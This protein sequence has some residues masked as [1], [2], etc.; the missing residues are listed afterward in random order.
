MFIHLT[1][2]LV[3]G[4]LVLISVVTIVSAIVFSSPVD[5]TRLTFGQRMDEETVLEKKR[6][7]GLDL[8]LKD[9]LVLYLADL[10]PIALINKERWIEL[11]Y[12]GVVLFSLDKSVFVF[13]SSYLRESFH[14]GRPVSDILFSA[15]PNTLILAISAITISA[16]LGIFLGT[17]AFLKKGSV[18]DDIIL[19]VSTIGYSVP[20]YVSATFFALIFAYYLSDFTG[21]NL[22]GSLWELDDF[23]NERF[24]LK[25]LLLPCLALAIRPV[26]V[27]TQLMRNSMLEVGNSPFIRAL[28]AKGLSNRR[29]LVKHMI[30]NALNPVV[31]ALSGWFA[32]LLTGAF[33]VEYVFSFKGLG[34][35]TIN[36][37]LNFDIPV[38]LGAIILST[39][40][41]ITINILIDNVYKWLDPRVA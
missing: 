20:S 11:P 40:F 31:T 32:S 16:L 38:V 36:S 6:Q 33:F 28:K 34:F 41:F 8:P 4:L 39:L 26:A 29:I 18:F 24:V 25:N 22:Q 23:G 30:R 27:I 7:L 13:K 9:Q 5:P 3:S 35:T 1:K 37:L 21:L 19:A 15:L 10:S 2:S 17:L 14:T 12:K